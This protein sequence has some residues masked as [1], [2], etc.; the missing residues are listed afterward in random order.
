[1]AYGQVHGDGGHVVDALEVV[2]T[3]VVGN[4]SLAAEDVDD[5]A[6]NLLQ[7][8]LG[9]ARHAA[10]AR[11]AALNLVEQAAVADHNRGDAL[12]KK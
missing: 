5:G 6:M 10:H 7:L 1:M 4:V 12:G 3:V 8:R 2:H 11:A 9:H